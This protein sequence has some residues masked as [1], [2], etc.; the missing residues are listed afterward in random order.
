MQSMTELTSATV[1]E[2]RQFAKEH[3]ITLTGAK[4]KADILERIRTALSIDSP[5]PKTKPAASKTASTERPERRA[6]IISDD[7]E[8]APVA[9]HPNPESLAIPATATTPGRTSTGKTKPAFNLTGARAWHNPQP[10]VAAPPPNKYAPPFG[11]GTR[12]PGIQESD[13]GHGVLNRPLPRVS[14]FGPDAGKA[15]DAV[16]VIPQGFRP[17]A[18]AQPS[19]VRTVAPVTEERVVPAPALPVRR[20]MEALS[21]APQPRVLR[22]AASVRARETGINPAV[23][24]ML[25][26]G[27][28]GDGAGVL[29]IHP[30]GYGFLRAGNFLPGKNDVYVSNAQIRRFGL[31][32]G[33]HIEGKTRA[34]REG[35]R[36]AAMLYIT[37]INGVEADEQRERRD[38]DDLTPTYPTR[39]LHLSSAEQNDPVLRFIDL[40][41]PIG[42]GQRALIVA[43]PK[44]GKTTILKKIALSIKAQQ[45]EAHL[46]VLLVDERPEEVTDLKESVGGDVFYSTFDEPAESHARVSELVADRARRLVEEGKDVVILLDSLT[47]LSRAYNTLAPNT[48]RIMSGGLAAGALN[49]PKRF[50][51]AARNLKEGGSLTIIATVIVET[52]SR[53]DDVIYEE[54]KGTGNMELTLDRS[55]QEMRLFPAVS[56]LR[57]GTRQEQLLL[58]PDEM[59]VAAR[60]RSMI[61]GASEQEGISMILSMMDRTKDNE[62][63]VA[64][65]DSWARMMSSGREGK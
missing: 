15:P 36:Y 24:E 30:D 43:P 59:Q 64:R 57:S 31:R 48:A 19:P 37:R 21:E 52:G 11:P 42:F 65:F 2:L 12:A 44:A 16:P 61:S 6:M 1:V 54:F 9:P 62:D 18:F 20:P 63:F 33:D 10:F 51:G 8:D 56:I 50:F 58:S 25:A 46:M 40:F 41:S 27:D 13:Q 34:Q 47:R 3:G 45:P 60:V 29:E 53:M 39:R 32:D 55:L 17:S 14:R 28:C 7:G 38:F 26:A 35:D 22:T 4:T 5:A 23:P 49:K